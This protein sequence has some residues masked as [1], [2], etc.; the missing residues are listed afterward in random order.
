[1]TPGWCESFG[2]ALAE[3]DEQKRAAA[4]GV[5]PRRNFR[6][7]RVRMAAS[8]AKG[9]RKGAV[10]KARARAAAEESEK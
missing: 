3:R 10:S 4:L 1:M 9:G 6:I 2:K 8:A 5:A 7:D